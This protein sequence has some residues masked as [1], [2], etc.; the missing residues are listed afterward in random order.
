MPS[1]DVTEGRL[2]NYLPY[3]LLLLQA[4]A[5]RT[6]T[7][8]EIWRPSEEM[9][10]GRFSTAE[11]LCD[12]VLSGVELNRYDV[13]GFSTVTS[14]F[15]YALRL[16][17]R[18]KHDFRKV[19][20]IFG[21]P[22]VTKLA[23]EILEKFEFVDG[24]FVGEAEASFTEFLRRCDEGA[25]ECAGIPGVATRA[26]FLPTVKTASLDD[27]PWV[28]EAPDFMPWFR[29]RNPEVD[30]STPISLEVTRGCP[31]Q[32]S[33]CSTRQVWGAQVRRKSVARL[34]EEMTVLS[35]MCGSRFFN[36]I[37]D[38]VG[39]PRAPFL[40]FCDELAAVN[41]GFTW[42]CSLKVDR[43][44]EDH[45]RRMWAA[46]MRSMFVGLESGNQQTLDRVRKKTDVEKEI[47]NIR[48]AVG[49]GFGVITS[50]I[51]GFPWEDE[52]DIEGTYR[53]HC[54]LIKSGIGRSQVNMLIP[55]PGTDI[56]TSGSILF[57]R[58]WL[59]IVSDGVAT[60]DEMAVATSAHPNL[61]T[62]FGRYETPQLRR[63]ELL[64]TFT[65][66]KVFQQMNENR[67]RRDWNKF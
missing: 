7:D 18:V 20:V 6:R 44:E 59:P 42:G 28:S 19:K 49:I 48:S 34:V 67:R 35:Q 32:C 5:R 13:V 26:G 50:F 8:V 22:F 65:A 10:R 51:I 57:E 11:A 40:A 66:A 29:L 56:V 55:I 15:L 58:D 12:A 31:L 25:A 61:F 52:K 53:L 2:E 45:L 36:L 47:A 33:F 41:P 38:N 21:G 54:D 23:S 30:A 16:A 64:L 39:V 3:G 27:L 24:I 9:L 17:A 63:D 1:L 14:S 4:I 43:L 60:A 46:G 62:H 37:G